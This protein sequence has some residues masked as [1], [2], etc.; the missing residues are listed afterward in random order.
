MNTVY[1]SVRKPSTVRPLTVAESCRQHAVTF[2]DKAGK[3]LQ[4]FGVKMDLESA[5]RVSN[6]V[7]A[8]R[9][10]EELFTGLF[11]EDPDSIQLFRDLVKTTG[12]RVVYKLNE[13]RN[14]KPVFRCYALIP[15]ARTDVVLPLLDRERTGQ[16]LAVVEALQRTDLFLPDDPAHD[17][18]AELGM[19]DS[20]GLLRYEKPIIIRAIEIIARKRFGEHL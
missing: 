18:L 16:L 13:I 10:T 20:V 1:S 9:K 17:L 5:F 8:K 3:E 6:P 11:A 7:T 15:V 19:I 12:R 4:P 14:L 2:L